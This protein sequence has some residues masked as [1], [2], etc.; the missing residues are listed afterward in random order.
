MTG[1]VIAVACGVLRDVQGRVLIAQRPVGKIAAGKWEFPGGKIEPG[2]GARAA[3]QRELH[4]ELG[5]TICEMRPLIFVE[6]DYSD[7]RVLL[8]TWL[9]STWEG[10][11]HGREHQALAW[12]APQ[13]LPDY[14][15]LAADGPIVRAL[16]LPTDYV[17]T[18]PHFSAVQALAQLPQLPARALL[19]LR[20]PMMSAPGYERCARAA[21]ERGVKVILDR[22]PAQ[23][24]NLGAA[25]WHASA[26]AAAGL[27]QRPLP[28]HIW[29]LGSAHNASQLAHLR[30]LGADAA[31]LGPVC[32]TPSHAGAT[33]LGWDTFSALVR[34][35]G[36]PVYAIGGVGPAQAAQAHAKYAQGTAG[37]SAYWNLSGG[38]A[39]S[40]GSV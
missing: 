4:E 14:E 25:G 28:E 18:P 17:F 15:L 23:V 9:V 29:M 26:A 39:S 35:A 20:L 27:R 3:L 38:V 2:E 30:S 7:R 37:I 34:D 1:P 40:A 32:A 11:P 22:E 36:M 16:R 21:I 24:L 19:R 33:A 31:V 6:H 12:C 8:D 5:V 10:V 13:R